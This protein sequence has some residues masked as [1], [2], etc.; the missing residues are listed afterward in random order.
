M[1][2]VYTKR[3]LENLEDRYEFLFPVPY[4]SNTTPDELVEL[5]EISFTAITSQLIKDDFSLIVCIPHLPVIK[6]LKQAEVLST[7]HSFRLLRIPSQNYNAVIEEFLMENSISLK[8]FWIKSIQEL[9][10]ELPKTSYERIKLV[11][12]NQNEIYSFWLEDQECI[13]ATWN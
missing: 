3:D 11:N 10:F 9:Q 6:A 12:V 7:S 5:E 13:V 1:K 8:F 2:R 4:E